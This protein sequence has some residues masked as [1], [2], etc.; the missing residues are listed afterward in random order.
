MPERRA[1]LLTFLPGGVLERSFADRRITSARK[2]S[3]IWSRRRRSALH[4]ASAGPPVGR[5]NQFDPFSGNDPRVPPVKRR[6]A[7]Y[8]Q[9]AAWT[10]ISQMLWRRGVAR[11]AACA[12][13]TRL[14]DPRRFVPCHDGLL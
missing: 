10:T 12:G 7:A 9:Y 1:K 6:A 5:L 11:H 2:A 3:C 14:T 4:S 13:V 8:F